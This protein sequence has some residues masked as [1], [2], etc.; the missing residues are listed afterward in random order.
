MVAALAG[1]DSLST[2]FLFRRDIT[3]P[4]LS[5]GLAE[6]GGADGARIIKPSP[7]ALPAGAVWPHS[8]LQNDAAEEIRED[9]EPV[10]ATHVAGRIDTMKEGAGLPERL[11]ERRQTMGF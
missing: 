11:R 5:L 4:G 2:F 9:L 10:E 6:E 7:L 8:P 3:A 1:A